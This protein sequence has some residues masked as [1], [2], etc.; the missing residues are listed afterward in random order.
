MLI[1]DGSNIRC[2]QSEEDA[3]S[4]L[5]GALGAMHLRTLGLIM[6]VTWERFS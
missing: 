1:A 2:A 6:K 4:T 5:A 3:V